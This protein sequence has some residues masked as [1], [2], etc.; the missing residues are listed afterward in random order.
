MYSMVRA[1]LRPFNPLLAEN[2]FQTLSPTAADAMRKAAMPLFLDL[3]L[4]FVKV[5]DLMFIAPSIPHLRNLQLD[6]QYHEALPD[7]S[8]LGRLAAPAKWTEDPDC[9]SYLGFTPGTKSYVN[10]DLVSET[11][12]KTA[13]VG[14]TP[15]PSMRVPRVGLVEIKRGEPEYEDLARQQDLEDGEVNGEVVKE[16]ANGHADAEKSEGE[17]LKKEESDAGVTNGV[18]ANG[19]M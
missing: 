1:D 17:A 14:P 6:V 18:G 5:A 19:I 12:A 15:F 7:E 3:D 13:V 9:E 16:G 10:G 8:W 4:F 11:G 2:P